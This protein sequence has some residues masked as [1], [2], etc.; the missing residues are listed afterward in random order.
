MGIDFS[1]FSAEFKAKFEEAV[2]DKKITA[3]EFKGF[4][5]ADQDLLS[6]LIA[7]DSQALGDVVVVRDEIRKNNNTLEFYAG[8]DKNEGRLDLQPDTLEKYPNASYGYLKDGVVTLYNKNGEVL[9]NILGQPIKF[10]YSD[11]IQPVSEIED[12]EGNFEI[13]EDEDFMRTNRRFAVALIQ[14]MYNRVIQENQQMLQSLG[15]LDVGFWREV[16]GMGIQWIADLKQDQELITASTLKRIE[17]IESERDNICNSLKDLIDSPEEFADKF[18]QLVGASYGN[19]NF[20]KLRDIC[21]NKENE[22]DSHIRYSK[23]VEE[24]IS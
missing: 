4:S 22:K 14:S 15:A 1:K 18:S 21:H 6:S 16:M 17:R 11:V 2:K 10:N 8:N 5:K 12:V 20:E 23:C 24:P 3:E 13:P 19:M 7:G 9:K